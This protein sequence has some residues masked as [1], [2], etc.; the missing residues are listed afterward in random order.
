MIDSKSIA[1]LIVR[2]RV[3]FFDGEIREIYYICVL[4]NNYRTS[5]N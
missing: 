1:G 2:G 4:C 5:I 3:F